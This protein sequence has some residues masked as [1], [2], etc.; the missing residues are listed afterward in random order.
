MK[1][2]NNVEKDVSVGT[3]KNASLGADVGDINTI[4]FNWNFD[5]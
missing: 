1:N 4:T 5:S 3:D 2:M